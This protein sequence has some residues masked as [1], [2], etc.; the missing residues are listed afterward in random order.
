MS[1]FGTIE[2]AYLES[3]SEVKN[4]NLTKDQIELS[5]WLMKIEK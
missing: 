5:N 1:Q 4:H 3:G 2:K